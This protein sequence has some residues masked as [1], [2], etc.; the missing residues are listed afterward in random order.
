MVKSACGI[1]AV[2]MCAFGVTSQHFRGAYLSSN[3]DIV[4]WY[5]VYKEVA[6]F[7]LGF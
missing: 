3:V 2:Y 7:V 6:E 4:E 5:W 1:K